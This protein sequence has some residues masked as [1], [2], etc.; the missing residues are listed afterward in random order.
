MDAD[1]RARAREL[2]RPHAAVTWGR[3]AEP[4]RYEFKLT[5]TRDGAATTATTSLNVD[6]AGSGF[7]NPILPGMFPDPHVFEH[8]GRFY[9]YATSMENDAGAYGRASVWSSDDFV[10]WEMKLTDWPEYGTFGGDIWAPDILKKDGRFH[11][12]V[13]R[14]GSYDTWVGVA[15]H[16]EGPWRNLRGD[17]TPIVSGGGRAGRIVPAY[18]MDAQPFLDEDGQAYMYWGWSEAMA[19]KLTPDLKEIEGDVHFLK[20][21]KWLPDGGKLPQWFSVDLGGTVTVTRVVSSPEF[22]DVAYGFVIET[23]LDGLA[24]RG[25]ADRRENRTGTPG[26]GYIDEGSAPARFVRITFHHCGGHWAGLYDFS[27]F[28]GDRLVSRQGKAA[29][30]SSRG[31]GSE[32]AN[33]LDASNGPALADFVEGSYLIKRNGK[34][35]LLY[36]SGAL[37]DGTYNVRYAMADHPF[38]PFVTPP[39]HVILQSSPDQTTRGPGHN[40]VLKHGDR[41]I[42]VYHQHNQPHEGGALVFRQTCADLLEFNDDGTIKPVRPTRHGVGA[43]GPAPAPEEDLALGRYASPRASGAGRT[44]PSSPWITTTRASGWRRRTTF[45][46]RSPWTWPNLDIGRVETSFEYPTLSYKYT[47]ETSLDGKTWEPYADHSTAFTPAVSPRRDLREARAAFV[48]IT[49]QACQRPENGAGIYSFQVFARKPAPD[50][51]AAGPE[52]VRALPLSAVRLTGGPLKHAQ[53]LDAEYLLSLEPD[54]MMAWFRK[55]AGLRPKAEGYGGWDGGGKN[56]TGHIA[57]HYLSAVSLMWAATGDVRFKERA[58]RLVAEMKEVQSRYG[59]GYLGALAGGRERFAEVAKGDVRSGG[60]DLNG[61]WSP[62]YVL[63]KIYAGLRDAYRFTGNRDALACEVRFAEWAE[64]V[65]GKLDA[66]QVQRMLN[67]EFGGMNEVLVDLFVDTGDRRWLELSRRFEHEAV[68]GP[69]KRGEDRLDGLHGNT[70]VPKLLGSLARHVATGDAAD[71]A[72]ASFFWER[73]AH[74]HSYATGGHG[75]NE[76][77]GPPDRLADRVDGRTAETCNVYNMLKLTR[78]LFALTPDVR[79]AEFHERALFNHI[80]ASMDPEDGRTAYMVPVG[81]GVRQEYQDMSDSFTCC[82]GSGMESHALH[83]DGIYFESGDRLWV[84]LYTPSTAQWSSAGVGLT[85]E[86]DLPV[87]DAVSIRLTC[88]A[89]RRF[90]L[91]LRRPSWAGDGFTVAVNGEAV[92]DVPP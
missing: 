36:S 41:H 69:L 18:N 87:G 83:G 34:Y 16:P 49:L 86:T 19:A 5:A 48:R 28:A 24:W 56:L 89:P 85:V 76:Y 61:L 30:S 13:T 1:G 60:F 53:D 9:I 72:A 27:V 80:L 66:A 63:H 6:P 22:R 2:E 74:H 31:A 81:R 70:Q 14:S 21:T 44:R 15:D 10:N 38:G 26:D 50:P 78:R 51:G 33:A 8:E 12:F 79:Y 77:F 71:G 17:D 64:S 43:L 11:Q 58:D 82:V 67:T 29:A 4:G 65:V 20:G 75:R 54:R 40:S 3:A 47:V 84:N 23:S 45:P 39:G 91:S 57:G 46:R 90:R 25:F 88:G 68:L 32:P 55:G 42:I 62:W 92:R 35:Y 59:D 73:V 7:G 52:T 37:H